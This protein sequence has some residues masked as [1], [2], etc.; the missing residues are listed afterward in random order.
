MISGTIWRQYES[1]LLEHAMLIEKQIEEF[2]IS[3][4]MLR[5]ISISEARPTWCI[6]FEPEQPFTIRFP[7]QWMT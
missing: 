5:D 3:G 1:A 6:N 4:A 7:D 2:L